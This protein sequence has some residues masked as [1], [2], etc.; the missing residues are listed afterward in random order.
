MPCPPGMFSTDG[1]TCKEC[2]D[3]EFQNVY[4]Q[5]ECKM[6]PFATRPLNDKTACVG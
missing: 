4:G 1:N 5:S 2:P 3:G 6:C